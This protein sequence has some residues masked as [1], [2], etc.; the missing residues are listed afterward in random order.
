[1]AAVILD[2]TK[3]EPD[4]PAPGSEPQ[5]FVELDSQGNPI[6][7]ERTEMLTSNKGDVLD[8]DLDE[9][10]KGSDDYPPHIPCLVWPC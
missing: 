3:T 2:L 1:M 4:A 5:V 6:A 10:P 9:G 8:L 7:V